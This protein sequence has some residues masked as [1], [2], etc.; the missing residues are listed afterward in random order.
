MKTSALKAFRRKLAANSPVYG[1][2]VTLEA[3]SITEMA[4]ALGLDWVVID[5]EHGHLDWKEI[6]EHLRAT[7][8]SDTVALVRVASLDIGLIK[9]AL[10]LGA[11]GVVI[12]WVESA[13]QFRQA[14]A[15]ARYPPEGLRGIGAERATCWGQCFVEHTAEANENVLVI[16]IIETVRTMRQVPLM[17]Q[18]D[19]AEVFYFGPADYSSTAG[20]RGQWEGPGVAEQILAMKDVIRRAGQHCGLIASSEADIAA[21]TA[22]GFQMIGLGMD[23]GLLI[24]S[25][26]SAL[27]SVQRSPRMVASLESEPSPAVPLERPPESMRP[28]RPEVMNAVGSGQ[29]VE[30]SAGVSFECLVGRHNQAR[31]LTTGR[32]TFAPEA[33][34]PYHSHPFT[35]SI[36]LLQGAASVEI[37]GRKYILKRMDNVTIP[38]GLAHSARNLSARDPAVFQVALATDNP[39]RT[40]VNKFFSKRTMPEDSTG[41]AGAER[42]NRFASAKRFAAGPNTEFIDFFNETLMPGLEVSGGYGLFAPGGRLPAHVHDFDESICITSGEAT[43]VVEGRRYRMSGGATALQPR[44][45][46]HYFINESKSPMEMLWVYA[47]PKPERIIVHEN[48]ATVEGDPWR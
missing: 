39:E 40:L 36:T 24:R 17:T 28:D 21:R 1:L 14:V 2:W 32:V 9:R 38:A 30:L 12:P 41:V 7:V 47:G 22:Q 10:D 4:V 3:P 48:C 27:Q 34:L 15:F 31:K 13:E 43:C 11:D 8:R 19:G 35:E 25:L 42:V 37:E 26:R 23:T 6:V 33:A 16:P 18:V 29:R 20:Y 46:V 5:A 45:R 44:G